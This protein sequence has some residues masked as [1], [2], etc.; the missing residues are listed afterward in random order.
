SSDVCSSDLVP[1][2]IADLTLTVP[3][4]DLDALKQMMAVHGDDV[5]AIIIEP[6]AGNMNMIEPLPGYLAA[7][8]TLC[9]EYG[10]IYIFDEVMTG[11]RVARGGAQELYNVTPDVTT[12]GKI[13]GGGLPVGACGGLRDV[14]GD[15]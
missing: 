4:N 3:F 1:K 7:I 13:I 6:I 5:A 2:A 15:R 10:S 8:R 9:D 12:F 11:F 14:M